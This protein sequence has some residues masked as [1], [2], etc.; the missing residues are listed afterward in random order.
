MLLL[1]LVDVDWLGLFCR[2]TLVGLLYSLDHLEDAVDP[3]S[4]LLASILICLNTFTNWFALEELSVVFPT[5][6]PSLDTLAFRLSISPLAIVY[7]SVRELALTSDES[8]L[9][10]LSFE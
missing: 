9:F 5:V 4:L 8:R 2:V 3:A 6:W 1:E 10:P 7:L